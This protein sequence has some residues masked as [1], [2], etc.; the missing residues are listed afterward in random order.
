[1][2]IWLASEKAHS[3]WIFLMGN[4]CLWI[5]YHLISYI[6]ESFPAKPLN[7]LDVKHVHVLMGRNYTTWTGLLI[8]YV[9]LNLMDGHGQ[10]ALLYIVP[11]TL[12]NIRLLTCLYLESYHV[13]IN[14][15]CLLLKIYEKMTD[16]YIL[17][18]WWQIRKKVV[19][20]L[21]FPLCCSLSIK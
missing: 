7:G 8:T 10:P 19:G 18:K 6:I 21:S 20:S 15:W 16:C 12:G 14:E 9:A 5:R 1:M 2:Q 3:S 17:G 13:W 4:D 11:F